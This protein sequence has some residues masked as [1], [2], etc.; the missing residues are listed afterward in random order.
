M[1]WLAFD[2]ETSELDRPM[3]VEV[4]A[5]LMED[6][7]ERA[8]V[9]LIVRPDGWRI[10]PGAA[11]V[12]G[13]TQEYAS[14]LGV[15]LVVAVSALTNLWANAEF[16][17]AHNLEFDEKVVALA[18]GHLGRTSSLPAPPGRCTMQLAAPILALPPT[19]R[20]IAAGYGDK[21]KSPS[22]AECCRHF[23]GEEP[24]GHHSALADAR[25]AARVYLAM[26][27][28]L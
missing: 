5:V 7:R 16:R 13:I 27:G 10:S 28:Q 22:L 4:G 21:P 8:A 24:A 18:C 15:P 14:A 12:H 19:E 17:V 11:R 23:F 1:I 2:T 6:D 25:S 9:S 26:L 20:M 3:L